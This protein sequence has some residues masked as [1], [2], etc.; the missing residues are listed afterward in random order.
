MSKID[1]H[2]HSNFSDGKFSPSQIIDM[3][4]EKN[5]PAIALT[6]HDNVEGNKEGIEYAKGK[7]IEFIA[8][9]EI[10]IT[11]PENCREVHMVG[12]FIDHNNAASKEVQPRSK[13]HRGERIRKI[14]E[15]CNQLGYNVSFEDFL[16]ESDGKHFGRP[17]LAEILLRKYP[18][19]FEDKQEVFK[20]LIGNR[21]K[22]FVR[23]KGIELP[24]AIKIIHE[25]GGIAIL[26]HPC[27]L[28]EDEKE[29]IAEFF[30]H[31]GD[32]L[33]RNCP[34]NPASI[35]SNWDYTDKVIKEKNLLVSGGTDFHQNEDLGSHGLSIEEFEKLKVYW[36]KKAKY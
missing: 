13:K 36:K 19:K 3:A 24:E 20:E 31:G 17:L 4:I 16:R 7:N 30:K 32:L 26:A 18:E 23:A 33:E 2:V 15:K 25:A 10:T 22:A 1:L 27:Y 8:G 12:L 9:I 6:D 14:I 21:G 29:V 28:N 11:P 5:M 35:G 34:I